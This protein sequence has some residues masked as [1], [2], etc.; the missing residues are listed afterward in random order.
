ML[1]GFLQPLP[2]IAILRGVRPTEV[3]AI[4][5][6]LLE[7]GIRIIEVP[8]NSPSPLDSI[9]SLQSA[10]GDRALIGA[11]TIL[12]TSDL[13]AVATAGGRL[14]V[15]PHAATDIIARA[16]HHGMVC[17]PGVA[18]PT[19]CFAA[20]AAG[21]DAVKLFPAEMIAPAV[22]KSM[23]AVLPIGTRL[24]PVGGI[25]P[26]NMASYVEAGVA[27]FG[28]GS[29]LY[30][31]GM[32]VQDVSRNARTFRDRWQSIHT[33]AMAASGSHVV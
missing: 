18:T 19:E 13:D 16:K 28:I 7:T 15:M 21:A 14:A 4:A 1:D 30:K 2:F 9:A 24:F 20:L 33:A 27:G 26:G 32:T 6:A 22:V 8:L 3:T 25:S 17:I 10:F 29:S 31:P 12:N 5:E 23:R 11:G